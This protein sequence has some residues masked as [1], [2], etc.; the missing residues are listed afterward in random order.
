[1]KVS[2][3]K[4]TRA[5]LIALATTFIGQ[6]VAFVPA[7]APDK[8]VLIS[9]VSGLISAAFLVA[10]GVH[11][12]ASSNVSVEDLKSGVLDFVH[13]ELGKINFSALVHDAVQKHSVADVEQLVR[14]EIQKL[15]TGAI[16][17]PAAPSVTPPAPA[18]APPAQ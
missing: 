14:T 15:L 6:L 3:L 9:A 11:A 7:F 16:A 12:L 13:T 4:V 2:H 1:M 5:G 18:P 10:N 17:T 8:Q